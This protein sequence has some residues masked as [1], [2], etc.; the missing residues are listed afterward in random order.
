MAVERLQLLANAA[1]VKEPID[2]AK[3][4]IVRHVILKAEVVEK[5]LRSRLRPHHRPIL[6]ANL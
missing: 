5:P 4:M 1:Q 3:Q 6:P 2:P